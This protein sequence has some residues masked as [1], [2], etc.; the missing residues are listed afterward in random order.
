MVTTVMIP[1]RP[2]VLMANGRRLLASARAVTRA[3]ELPI[4]RKLKVPR[5]RPMQA[6]RPSHGWPNAM[7]ATRA[8]TP[9]RSA[10]ETVRRATSGTLGSE[11]WANTVRP[12]PLV[13]DQVPGDRR[14]TRS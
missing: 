6:P 13:G 9:N 14:E 7:Q 8:A 4:I 2:N 11:K 1:I 3:T 5:A 10:A 12:G